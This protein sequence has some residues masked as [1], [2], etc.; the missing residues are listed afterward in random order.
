MIFIEER[1]TPGWNVWGECRFYEV[2]DPLLSSLLQAIK[3]CRQ[4]CPPGYLMHFSYGWIP[5]SLVNNN[6]KLTKLFNSCWKLLLLKSIKSTWF[7]Q[8][9]NNFVSFQGFILMKNALNN[10]VGMLG[11][12]FLWLVANLKQGVIYFKKQALP[13]NISAGSVRLLCST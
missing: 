7:Q 10:Q 4:T 9:F 11:D 3:T 2:N 5:E 12:M 1:Y 8:T 6:S 13:P